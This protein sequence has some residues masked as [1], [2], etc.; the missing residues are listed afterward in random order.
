MRH[1][2]Q[3][4]PTAPKDLAGDGVRAA[5][6]HRLAVATDPPP[7]DGGTAVA[8]LPDSVF[9][10]APATE[11]APTAMGHPVVTP[12]RLS[13]IPWA[14]TDPDGLRP[15]RVPP[16]GPDIG[17]WADPPWWGR[18]RWAPSRLAGIALV[19]LV[20]ALGAFSV[21]RLLAAV[22]AGPAVPELPM[23]E[24]GETVAPDGSS[25]GT[26]TAVTAQAEKTG[27]TGLAEA[28]L[29][30]S[31]VGLVGRSGLVTVAPGAR[32][33]DVLD[34]AGG[35]LEGGDRDGLNLARKVV[36][37]EQIL[38][39]LAPGPEGLRGPRSGIVGADSMPAPA[40][41]SPAGA[42]PPRGAAPGGG[43]LVN[44]NA[45]DATGLES[46]PGVGPVTAAAILSWREANGPFSSVDQ[47]AEVDGIGPA[48]LGRLRPL[49]TV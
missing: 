30:V 21:H 20:V 29:V 23:D 19:V 25:S 4:R 43:G 36:D 41:P 24:P 22:P 46:L 28:P 38:V 8:S 17:A 7:P 13:G 47:L 2:T 35:V 1:D 15:E 6:L 14:N 49:V 33:A 26:S 32:V 9:G 48:T 12:E 5:A 3:T 39:G 42:S 40:G 37:G 34:S 11:S 27:E 16:D 10:P 18:I 44:I 45:A 31:V